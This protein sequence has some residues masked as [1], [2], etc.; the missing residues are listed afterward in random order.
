[1]VPAVNSIV[2]LNT[3]EHKVIP[4]IRNVWVANIVRR[5]WYAMVYDVPLPFAVVPGEFIM[6]P[7]ADIQL[8]LCIC[9]GTLA[10]AL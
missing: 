6:A 3:K 9:L 1:M 5:Q 7:L 4:S 8:R 10:P 2:T